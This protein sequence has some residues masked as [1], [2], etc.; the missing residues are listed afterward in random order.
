MRRTDKRSFSLQF[1]QSFEKL[2][3]SEGFL[4]LFLLFLPLRQFLL[5]AHPGLRRPT[6]SGEE[7]PAIY[8]APKG[9]G[10][11]RFY[12]R[13]PPLHFCIIAFSL[14]E[15]PGGSDEPSAD[16]NSHWPIFNRDAYARDEFDQVIGQ[17]I[18][19]CAAYKQQGRNAHLPQSHA[20]Y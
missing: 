3:A 14:Y 13:L 9:G 16:G 7:N 2:L 4:L 18:Q 17:K 6:R 15:F 10:G 5:L 19:Q 1:E 20:I 12:L 11:R 8:N